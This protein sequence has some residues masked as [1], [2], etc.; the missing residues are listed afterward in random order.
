[1][2]SSSYF[3][4]VFSA[5]KIV[6]AP[7]RQALGRDKFEMLVL[8]S[9]NKEFIKSVQDGGTFTIDALVESLK[10]AASATEA[11]N[12]LIQ[13]FGIDVELDD[14]D[15]SEEGLRIATILRSAAKFIEDQEFLESSEASKKR[16]LS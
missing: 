11:A 16:K 3:E 4:R 15:Q 6:D 10:C 12:N 13:F 7:L 14:D 5:S 2:T 8:L 9:F 1:M